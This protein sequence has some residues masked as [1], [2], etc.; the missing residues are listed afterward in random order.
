[1]VEYPWVRS[2]FGRSVED[3]LKLVGPMVVGRGGMICK[4]TRPKR[5]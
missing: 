1:M 3:V 4:R 5:E 2:P